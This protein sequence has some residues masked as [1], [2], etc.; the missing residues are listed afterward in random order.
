MTKRSSLHAIAA[1]WLL[2]GFI[3]QTAVADPVPLPITSGVL[4]YP[5]LSEARLRIFFANG[6]ATIEWSNEQGD[7]PPDYF[8][9]CVPGTSL[10]LSTDESFPNPFG[11][12]FGEVLFGPD[13]YSVT[14]FDFSVVALRDIMV[15][16]LEGEERLFFTG[17]PFTFRGTV[18][19]T[20]SGQRTLALNLIGLGGASGFFSSLGP[21]L[22]DLG[23][24]TYNFETNTPSPVPEPGTWLLVA[25]G[26]GAVLRRMGKNRRE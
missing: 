6:S 3:P 16:S 25:T 15:P 20:A 21:D 22:T 14:G 23:F 12:H 8:P 24:P 13:I 11:R 19:G 9:C 2:L 10:N 1:V 7:W 18:F 26:L 5:L 17:I 4:S